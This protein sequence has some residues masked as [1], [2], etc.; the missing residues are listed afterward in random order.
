M[1]S[2]G[3]FQSVKVYPI[4]N[5]VTE[6]GKQLV[7]V[8]IDLEEK[9]FGSGEIAL[10]YR[11]D[12]GARASLGILYNNFV[13]RNWI[14][15]FDLQS[16]YRFNFSNIDRDR[17]PEDTKFIEFGGNAGFTFPYF[18]SM[19]LS[20]SLNLSTKNNVFMVLMQRF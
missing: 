19:P 1:S 14:G 8:F 7:D 9:D 17:N 20:T 11:T 2:L 15:S 13:G 3:L 5:K 4:K 16:N 10:G 6:A 18:Y 12:I